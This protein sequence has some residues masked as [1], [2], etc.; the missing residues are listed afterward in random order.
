MHRGC[1]LGVKGRMDCVQAGFNRT[2]EVSNS[3]LVYLAKFGA[4]TV[5]SCRLVFARGFPK[6]RVEVLVPRV[7]AHS[8]VRL[9]GFSRI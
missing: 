2:V 3:E 9:Y 6:L 1:E 5:Q 4:F 8:C 7:F